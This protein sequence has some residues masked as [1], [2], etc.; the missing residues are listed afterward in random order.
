MRRLTRTLVKVKNAIRPVARKILPPKGYMRLAD[1]VQKVMAGLL[2]LPAVR[3]REYVVPVDQPLVYI[4]QAP[5]S[6]GTLLRNLFDGHSHCLVVPEELGF[7][8]EEF[9]WEDSLRKISSSK[10]AFN[11]LRERWIDGAVV[12]GIDG[13]YPFVF[14]RREQKRLFFSDA[15]GGV[16]DSD[17]YWL[18]LY[19]TSFFNAWYD[20]QNL[21]GVNHTYVV[22]FCPWN[23]SDSSSLERFFDWY[24]DGHR[25]Q[26]I[27]DPRG[28]WASERAYGED[29]SKDAGAYLRARWVPAVRVGIEMADR[30]PDRYHLVSFDRLVRDPEATM[31]RL[32]GVLGIQF[33]KSL[34]TPTINR[35]PRSSNT[36][37][38]VDVIQIDPGAADRWREALPAEERE[39]VEDEALEIYREVRGR[40]L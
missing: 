4:S 21:Y 14:S 13:E 28:W 5:R 29:D 35:W 38:D 22:A 31:S 8:K 7:E 34:L 25:I 40:C 15:F 9:E 17:R 6:G 33:Q 39:T 19:F 30:Y 36:S 26:V 20:Y 16:E 12:N 18:D 37:F 11:L 27:R 10:E 2:D 3:G 32:A 1:G 24:P 23:L